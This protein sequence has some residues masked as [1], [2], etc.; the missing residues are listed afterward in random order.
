MNLL[1]Y[2]VAGNI[3][4]ALRGVDATPQRCLESLELQP[5]ITELADDLMACPV[6]P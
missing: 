4:G 3:M 1:G 2:Y 5:V 6:A